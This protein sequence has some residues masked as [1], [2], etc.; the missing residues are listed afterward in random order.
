[1]ADHWREGRPWEMLCL[2]TAAFMLFLVSGC[3]R[4]GGR[5]GLLLQTS[6]HGSGQ[7]RTGSR[8]PRTAG[9][10][11]REEQV[12]GGGAEMGEPGWW[13]GHMRRQDEVPGTSWVPGSRRPAHPVPPPPGL[14]GRPGLGHR[15][16]DITARFGPVQ[17]QLPS[18]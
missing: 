11:W 7:P 4:S 2:L 10:S 8:V 6:P 5:T 14:P 15:T 3:R 9:R 1:M 12:V 18:Y 13:D 17:P 16:V